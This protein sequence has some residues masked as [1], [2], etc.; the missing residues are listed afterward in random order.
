[1]IYQPHFLAKEGVVLIKSAQD[2]LGIGPR[3]R[4]T[5]DFRDVEWLCSRTVL[6]RWVTRRG[7]VA[8]VDAD[9]LDTSSLD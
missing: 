9:E 7:G 6:V 4:K 1:M 8:W 2:G 5:W 3:N